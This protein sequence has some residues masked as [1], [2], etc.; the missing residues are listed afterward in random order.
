MQTAVLETPRTAPVLNKSLR[1]HRLE[2]D[3][4]MF[5]RTIVGHHEHVHRQAVARPELLRLL[6]AI[7]HGQTLEDLSG[8]VRANEIADLLNELLALGCIEPVSLAYCDL[9]DPG[10]QVLQSNVNYPPRDFEALRRTVLNSATELLGQGV[11]QYL[12]SIYSCAD[13][14]QLRATIDQIMNH[15][16]TECGEASVQLFVQSVRAVARQN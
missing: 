4:V 11:V 3:D 8:I 1:V 12:E 10:L 6:D 14:V 16:R 15:I 5:R 7:D 2:V 13:S 9:P